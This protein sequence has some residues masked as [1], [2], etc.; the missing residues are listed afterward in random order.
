MS[1]NKLIS[2]ILIV[3]IC[4]S[5]V[6]FFLLYNRYISS[7]TQMAIEVYREHEEIVDALRYERVAAYN[8]TEFNELMRV[9][10]LSLQRGVLRKYE[11]GQALCPPT[12]VLYAMV[13][14]DEYIRQKCTVFAQEK[15]YYGDFY[16][17]VL[18]ERPIVSVARSRY[19]LMYQ[20]YY[21]WFTNAED[22]V[23]VAPI[24]APGTFEAPRAYRLR[25]GHQTALDLFFMSVTKEANE[26]I[27]PS[28]FSHTSGIVIAAANG[29]DENVYDIQGGLSPHSGNG[30]VVY[31][32]FA[33]RYYFY[34]HLHDIVVYPGQI[35]RAGALIGHGGNTGINARKPNKGEHVHVE[36]YDCRKNEFFN[37]YEI[38][39]ILYDRYYRQ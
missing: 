29:W 28:L 7:S 13:A 9:V 33:E 11:L 10:Y 14:S 24:A 38:K 18:I 25:Q 27:G 15:G 19:E 39:E 16:R 6:T 21:A 36:I 37:V 30:V 1:R 17:K 23:S 35:I 5:T 26:E 22:R 2:Y 4:C 3:V 20:T 12:T 31:D 32:P 8:D 34:F